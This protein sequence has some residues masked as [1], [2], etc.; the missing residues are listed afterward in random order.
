MRSLTVVAIVCSVVVNV[1]GSVVGVVVVGHGAA[2]AAPRSARETVK[3]AQAHLLADETDAAL[4]LV[5]EGLATWPKSK[6]LLLLRGHV[7]LKMSDYGAALDAYNRYLAAGATGGNR[8]EVLRIVDSLRSVTSTFLEV[9]VTNGPAN[10]F[11]DTRGGKPFCVAEPTCKRGVVPGD[12]LLVIDRAGFK[13]VAERMFIPANQ[14]TTVDRTLAEKP[15][16][17]ALKVTPAD[18]KIE[19]DGA[20]APKEL[21]PGPHTVVARRDG[22]VPGTQGVTAAEGKPVDVTL[23]LAPG[24]AVDVVPAEAKLFVDGAETAAVG[25]LLPLPGPGAHEIIARAPGYRERG[26]T[27]PAERP[28]GYRVALTLESAGAVLAAVRGAPAGAALFIDGQPRGALPLAAPVELAPGEHTIVVS[29]AGYLPFQRTATFA[30]RQTATVQLSDL[31]QPGKTK[32]WIAGGV[33]AAGLAVGGVFGIL[34]LK[35]M[36]D[37]DDRAAQAGVTH[38][39]QEILDLESAGKRNAVISDISLGI[40]LVALGASVY[41]FSTEGKGFSDGDIVLT[42]MGVAGRF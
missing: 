14:V 36:S 38:M 32:A 2:A 3:V 11:L 21:A 1:V 33:A 17:L 27:V 40:G 16:P 5:E 6:E 15:S 41:W 42:P 20:P 30:E 35:K 23:A 26:A 10:V 12:H 18:A 4:A 25:G 13:R 22:Y 29:A 7:L 28:A 34:A 9:K 39:T 24:V 37:Y 8:R 31:R 19:V